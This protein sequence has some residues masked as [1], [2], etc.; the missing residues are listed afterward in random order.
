MASISFTGNDSVVLYDANN[1]GGIPL[2]D[3]GDGDVLTIDWGADIANT[4]V[5]KN[6]NVINA[7][8][9][10]GDLADVVLR[11]LRGSDDDILL[12]ADEASYMQ[13]PA[14]FQTLAITATKFIGDGNGVFIRDV[15]TLTFGTPKRH[16]NMKEN[17][18][19]DTE[20]ALAVHS[21]NFV[22]VPN[23]SPRQLG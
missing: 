20:Q 23:N 8:N 2:T 1:P 10:E 9:A 17:V 19:G 7:R 18:S 6:G 12:N 14:L 22:C 5:G 13:N 15:Y 16:V 11:V 4:K 21:Y 3:F